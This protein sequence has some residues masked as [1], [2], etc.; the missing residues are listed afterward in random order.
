MKILYLSIISILLLSSCEEMILGEDE[1]NNPE[2]NFEILWNDFDQHY[3]LFMVRQINWD[4]LYSVYRPQVNSQTTDAELWSIFTQLLEHL[5][6]SHTGIENLETDENYISGFILNEQSSLGFNEDLITDKYLDYRTIVETETKL[7]YG[8]IKNKNIAYIYLGAEDGESPEKIDDVIQNLKSLN[9]IILDVRQNEGGYDTYAARIAGAFA[10]SE[11]LIYSVQTRNGKNHSDFDEKK[12]FYTKKQGN[13]QF[14][15]PVIVLTDRYTISAGEVLLLHLKSF[16]H[17][18][19][20]GDTTAGDFS[21]V[22][23]MRFLPNGWVYHYSI[24]MYLLPDGKSLDGIGHIPDVYIKNN[25]TDIQSQNDKVLEKAIDY[26]F[27]T[28]GID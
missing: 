3:G 9:A 8:K 20:I 15:K 1:K 10:D 26:L 19:Q 28:Y 18:T 25:Q 13:E 12:L 21:D 27:D 22:S 7:S 23:N 6:D 24:M 14:I 4:S 16:S 5:D 2:N 11:K 17:V